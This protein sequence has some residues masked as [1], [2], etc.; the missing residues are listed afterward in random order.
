MYQNK[1]ILAI[2]PARSG[3]KGMKDKNI[4]L[5]HGKPLLAYAI[6]S[7]KKSDVFEDIVVSTDSQQ[8]AEIARK[9]GAS[10]PELRPDSL[11]HDT[12]MVAD[13]INYILDLYKIQGKTYDYFALL[14][15]TSPL[16]TE[17]HI[18]EAVT[19]LLDK[20][21]DSVIGVCQCDHPIEW[22][23]KESKL[24]DLSFFNDSSYKRPRQKIETSYRLNGAMFLASVPMFQ[25]SQSFYGGSSMGYVMSR[26]DSVDIDTPLDFKLA[27]F[28]IG[29]KEGECI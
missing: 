14:Q 12:A 10:V 7:A 23:F 4:A 27:E 9:Y 28:L 26:E 24:T 6:D 16:R 18:Q 21:V 8:Y 17:K 20:N 1:K 13:T 22:S 29:T 15:P 19:L 5:L 3:S 2:I 25:S 11:S